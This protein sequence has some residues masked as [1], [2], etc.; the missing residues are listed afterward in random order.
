MTE[1]AVGFLGFGNMAQAMA[2]G[3]RRG[4]VSP[5]NLLACAAHFEKLEKNAA[6]LEVTPCR[7]GAETAER[8]DI[9]IAAVKPA[10]MGAVDAAQNRRN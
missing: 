3:L 4:G 8:C 5:Q 7:S 1:K 2:R 9:L 10:V 6:V